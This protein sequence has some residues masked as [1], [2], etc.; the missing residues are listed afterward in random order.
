MRGW[1][2]LDAHILRDIGLDHGLVPEDIGR[3]PNERRIRR[4]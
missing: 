1:E 4:A 3:R 2:T